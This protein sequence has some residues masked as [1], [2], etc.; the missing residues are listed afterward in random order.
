V[1]RRIRARIKD[2]PVYLR[3]AWLGTRMS[4]SG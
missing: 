1:I 3:Q 4:P 2:S